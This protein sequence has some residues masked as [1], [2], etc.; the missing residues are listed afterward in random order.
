LIGGVVGGVIV[1]VVV[2]LALLIAGGVYF[3]RRRRRL[4]SNSTSSDNSK[5]AAA[6]SIYGILPLKPIEP[7]YQLSPATDSGSKP[8]F[9]S[10]YL[11]APS[12]YGAPPATLEQQ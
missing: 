3:M 1:G 4:G 2:V 6:D 5:P 12:H 8:M 11:D 9:R 10:S 7:V